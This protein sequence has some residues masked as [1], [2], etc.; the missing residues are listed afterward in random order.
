[1][2]IK[3]SCMAEEINTFS[4]IDIPISEVHTSILVWN[5]WSETFENWIYYSIWTLF[6]SKLK[7]WCVDLFV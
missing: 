2:V 6:L 7:K 4:G 5:K 1:M 3:I